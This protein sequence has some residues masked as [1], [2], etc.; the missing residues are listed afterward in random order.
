MTGWDYL[1]LWPV[2]LGLVALLVAI[3]KVVFQLQKLIDWQKEAAPTLGIM[4]ATV[5]ALVG[6]PERL[7]TLERK[8]DRIT[9]R[10]RDLERLREDI[11]GLDDDMSGV[12][13]AILSGRRPPPRNRRAPRTPPSGVPMLL[14]DD[15][16]ESNE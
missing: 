16:T 9:P 15:K 6:V 1:K 2:F 7:A 4:S 12:R 8:V 14:P 3:T 13:E 5:K 10:M 11:D